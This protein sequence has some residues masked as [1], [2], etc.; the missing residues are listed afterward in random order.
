MGIF[1]IFLIN[2]AGKPTVMG[3]GSNT[4]IMSNLLFIRKIDL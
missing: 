3:D 1:F 4:K 2:I